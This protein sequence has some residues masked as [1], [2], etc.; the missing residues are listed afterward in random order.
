MI[1]PRVHG[2]FLGG[3]RDW[4]SRHSMIY[5]L[6]TQSSIFDFIR[7]REITAQGASNSDII[8]YRDEKHQVDFNLAIRFLNR[9]I[10]GFK[11]RCR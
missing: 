5:V 6:V 8:R 7:D 10:R 9:A 1:W 3:L 4:L 11:T 2:K